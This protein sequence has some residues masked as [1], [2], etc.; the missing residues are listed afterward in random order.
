MKPLPKPSMPA[1]HV[2]PEILLLFAPAPAQPVAF[3]L[4]LIAGSTHELC[5][6]ATRHLELSQEIRL[7]DP[8][9]MLGHLIATRPRVIRRTAHHEFA[10]RDQD[11]LHSERVCDLCRTFR[12][13]KRG[14]VVGHAACRQRRVTTIDGGTE[15]RGTKLARG[16]D[17]AERFADLSNLDLSDAFLRAAENFT[18]CPRRPGGLGGRT[19][20]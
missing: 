11:E 20:R 5:E 13:V 1:G 8:H 12:D 14:T 6:L 18:R 15:G 2:D 3:P 7:G 16:P 19:G 4:G 17:L 10:G 9:T